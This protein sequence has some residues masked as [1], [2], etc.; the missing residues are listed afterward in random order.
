MAIEEVI[1]RVGLGDV[2][3]RKCGQSYARVVSKLVKSDWRQLSDRR[4]FPMVKAAMRRGARLGMERFRMLLSEHATCGND[5]AV[6]QDGYA[7]HSYEDQ[8]G[9]WYDS[10]EDY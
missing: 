9:D 3:E 2:P 5:P 6:D 7:V 10:D 4:T 8:G 1:R